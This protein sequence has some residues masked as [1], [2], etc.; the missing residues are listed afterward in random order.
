VC[1]GIGDVEIRIIDE[2]S[3]RNDVAQLG[4]LDALEAAE[5]FRRHGENLR[6]AAKAE[7]ETKQGNGNDFHGWMQPG[8]AGRVSAKLAPAPDEVTG[9]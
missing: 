6:R 9:N 8:C 5:I 2:F 4:L 1:A 7:R 3:R